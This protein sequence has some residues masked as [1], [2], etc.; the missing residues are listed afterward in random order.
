VKADVQTPSWLTVEEGSPREGLGVLRALPTRAPAGG[1][2]LLGGWVVSISAEVLT[3]GRGL[4]NGAVLLDPAV[5][6]EHALIARTAA[7]W[8]ISNLSQR[9]PLEL[10]SQRLAPGATATLLPGVTLRLGDTYLQFLAA[11]SGASSAA[12]GEAG[13]PPTGAS[14][15]LG[16]GVTLQFALQGRARSGLWRALR[17]AGLA[18]GILCAALTLGTLALLG[19]QAT[20]HGGLLQAL[21]AAVAPLA[22]ALGVSALIFF[23]DRYERE[24]WPLLA[25]AFLW[26]AAIALPPALVVEQALSRLVGDVGP[27]GGAPAGLGGALLQAAGISLTEELVKGAGLVLLLLALRDQF[28]NVTDGILYGLAIGAGFA[29]VENFAYFALSPHTDLP[30]LFVSRIVLGWLGHSTFSALFGAGLGYARE[31]HRPRPYLRAPALGLAAAVLLHAIFDGVA[32]AAQSAGLGGTPGDL[33][34]LAALIGAYAPLFASQILLLRL[35]LAALE[36]EAAVLREHLAGEVVAGSVTPDEY[37]IV[38]D[39]VLRAAAERQAL[40]TLGPRA[41]LTARA[42]YQAL[43][44]LAV[45]RWHVAE[46]DAPKPALRQPEDAYRERILA[47]RRALQRRAQQTMMAHHG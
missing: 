39:A 47:L 16:P 15:V 45:R 35:L 27:A 26:G 40:L 23:F 38:Q 22:P 46:G 36:R 13:E 28:D 30:A 7:G 29:T 6:R 25:A 9:Q 19:R 32:L 2:P 20:L 5:S 21:A 34:A 33:L 8:R 42:L 10:G 11:R 4:E 12:S 37:V 31:A 41:Y 43:A 44:G 24:P 17:L 18:L 1:A 3:L 14:R